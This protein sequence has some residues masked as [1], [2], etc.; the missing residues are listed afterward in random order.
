MAADQTESRRAPAAPRSGTLASGDVTLSYRVFGTPSARAPILIMHGSNYYDSEDWVGVA[1]ALAGDREVAIFD[2]RGF[3]R[4]TWSA[5]KDYSLDAYM[6]DIVALVAHF[7]WKKPVIFGHSMSGRLAILFAARFPDSLS[8]LVIADSGL[9]R[10]S[11]GVYQLSLGNKPVVFESIEAAMRHFGALENPPRIAH[12]RARAEKAL[13]KV[14]GGYMLLKDPDYRNA[15]SQAPGA[16]QP[17]MRDIDF[18]EELKR[19]RCPAIIIRGLRSS[20]FPPDTL[21]RLE[22]GYPG[23]AWATVDSQHDMAAQA[24]QELVAAT[25]KFIE[26]A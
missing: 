19:V 16:P 10:G 14:D 18:L 12:D 23:I 1:A 7:G 13:R 17:Q 6:A 5:T 8:R 26:Q 25:R 20:R 15:Q 2:H 22:S 11:P 3:G 9:E 24:P 21:R 4:S